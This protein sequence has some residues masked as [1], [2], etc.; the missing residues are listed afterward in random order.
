MDGFVVRASWIVLRCTNS[1]MELAGVGEEKRSLRATG[2]E[3]L[4]LR[5][6]HILLSGHDC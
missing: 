5:R 1:A 4:L 3:C 6:A 2:M